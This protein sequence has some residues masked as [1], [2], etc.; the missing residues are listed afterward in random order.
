[1]ARAPQPQGGIYQ[2]NKRT[3]GQILSM[4]SPHITVPPWQRSYSWKRSHVQTFWEDLI[5]FDARWGAGANQEYF[6]GSIVLVAGRGGAHL[7]LDGQQRLATAAILI[8]AIRDRVRPFRPAAAARLQARF[9]A[10]FDD[11][12]DTYVNKL[13]LNEY[14]REYF[15]RCILED[16]DANYRPPEPE[17]PS[18]M[19]IADARGFFD[20]ALE[21]QCQRLS[22]Q[23]AFDRVLRIQTTLTDKMSVI[24]VSSDDEDSASDVF[25]TLN[26]RGIGLSTPDLLRNLLMRRANAADRNLIVELWRDVLQ[27][28]SDTKIK[29]F[30]RHYWIS[31]YGD[32]KTQSLYR[33]IKGYV[34]ANSVS[35]VSL[36]RG[37]SDASEMYR[38]ILDGVDDDIVI[39]SRLSEI[40]LIGSGATILFPFFLSA[41]QAIDLEDARKLIKLSENVFVRHSIILQR[42]NSRLE[43][44]LYDAARVLR[45]PDGVRNATR[46]LLDAAPADQEVS[47]AC[48]RLSIKAS[49]IQRYLLRAFEAHF[50]RTEELDVAVPGRVHIEHIYPQ[51]PP[52]DRRLE[53][54][55]R[56]LNRLGNLTLLSAKLN[57]QI[58]NGTYAQKSPRYLESDLELTRSLGVGSSWGPREIDARQQ[59]LAVAAPIIWPVNAV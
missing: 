28:E 7:L 25:E 39:A 13:T 16:R 42:E 31:N 35:S 11:A 14:D 40:S 4:T 50:R 3:I 43:N 59:R 41:R 46:L 12:S 57:R 47:A 51:S 26:D 8:S 2:P 27:F 45:A 52:N 1:M 38:D 17:L 29:S 30:L 37:L 44:T 56:V 24:E 6:L 19:S 32:V 23:Q 53:N 18:H 21:E 54:H 36:S 55:D 34:T 58:Q 33:E 22:P 49:G 15:N 5:R 48:A 20:D 9:L 10:D